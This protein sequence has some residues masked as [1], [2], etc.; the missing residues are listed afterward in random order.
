MTNRIDA[1]S[2]RQMIT[3]V[4]TLNILLTLAFCAA[5]LDAGAAEPIHGWGLADWGMTEA[6]VES[7]Y[8]DA[9]EKL[10]LGRSRRTEI[11]EPLHLKKPVLINGVAL[12]Q[13]FA[14]SRAT[15]GLERV[16][17]RANLSN[18]STEQCQGAY[19]RV[20]QYEVDQLKAPIE[21]KPALRSLH[22]IWHGT[23]A[24]AQLSLM[25]VTG[26]CLLTL[27][28][29]RA[30][31]PNLPSDGAADTKADKRST[32][33]PATTAPTTAAPPTTAP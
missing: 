21:E 6:Q 4:F 3:Y 27:V 11:V 14:F 24:D 33:G 17:L 13:S 5:A 1:A 12:A 16:V 8:G 26:R 18:V 9:V 28:Y 31:P 30:S 15:Q 10:P 2:P 29:K 20:R 22:A 19:G 23:A 25:E 32:T 7:A